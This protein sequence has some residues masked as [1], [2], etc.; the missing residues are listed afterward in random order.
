ML[1]TR[2][3][4]GS[5]QAHRPTSSSRPTE[6]S[7]F[8]L[9]PNPVS[10]CTSDGAIT[11]TRSPIRTR[12]AV[13]HRSVLRQ[14]S[15]PLPDMPVVVFSDDISL[16]P[17]EPAR[18]LPER[19]LTPRRGEPQPAEARR[20]LHQSVDP[21]PVDWI[22]L[23]LMATT[24]QHHVVS[25]STYS[26]WG[27]RF[28]DSPDP[29]Y[30][31][32]WMGWKLVQPI[33]PLDPAADVPGALAA[34]PC[35]PAS[36]ETV[37]S[38]TC[39]A[40]PR[41]AAL[42]T[43]VA[44]FLAQLLGRGD[45]RRRAEKGVAWTEPGRRGPSSTLV[46]MRVLV[47]GGAGTSDR[48]RRRPRERGHEVHVLDDLS[49][50]KAANLE[51]RLHEIRLVNGSILD[52]DVVDQEVEAAQLVFTSQQPSAS[53]TSS[54]GPS[55]R[56]SRTQWGPRTCCRRASGTGG[57]S[58]WRR[59]RRCTARPPRCRC[60]RTTIGRRG[61]RPCTDGR[62]RLRRRRTSTRARLRG[63]R[64]PCRG[65]PVLQLLWPRLEERG[66][67]RS[68]PTPA[69]IAC[70]RAHRR[71]RNREPRAVASPTSTT[72]CGE[73]CRRASRAAAEGLVFNL[74]TSRETT[75]RGSPR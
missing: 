19:Q 57:R 1:L 18:I 21:G 15:R 28:A 24:C 27:A 40:F 51:H 36:Q 39:A 34:E 53:D 63:E 2:S 3:A 73:P 58:S 49:T 9:C 47:T 71:P 12:V 52:V 8:R 43:A 70:W 65:P 44:E 55:R 54:T 14:R 22:D 32:P 4:T 42:I 17:A 60:R 46:T 59:R 41:A 35:R 5:S 68:S 30:P 10:R 48:P 20:E 56:C 72:P 33:G 7:R 61:P 25:T 38:T 50:G 31:D 66:Y 26:W 74:G 16:L 75:I 67:G 37:S 6:A 62:S 29:V 13:A 11:P 69:P 23:Q 45:R 64:S